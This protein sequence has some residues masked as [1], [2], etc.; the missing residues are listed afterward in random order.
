[1]LPAWSL[2]S[3]H[4]IT[5]STSTSTFLFILLPLLYCFIS[6]S[7]PLSSVSPV[8]LLPLH[9]MQPNHYDLL[10]QVHDD[11]RSV[12][13]LTR[14]AHQPPSREPHAFQQSRS[15]AAV[16]PTR[17]EGASSWFSPDICPT[18]GMSA[19][20][21]CIFIHSDLHALPVL[22]QKSL[23]LVPPPCTHYVII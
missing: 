5:A 14:E 3:S 20:F 22:F 17:S 2:I 11:P 13:R 15:P 12:G 9:I 21:P 18:P 16:A 1:M 10:G 19:P 7:H 8:N 23:L 6:S 4:L